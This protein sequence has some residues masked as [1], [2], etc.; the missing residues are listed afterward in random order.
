MN[1]MPGDKWVSIGMTLSMV[2]SI[3]GALFYIWGDNRDTW[4]YLVI[5]F[6][7]ILA[8]PSFS[9]FAIDTLYFGREGDSGK[10]EDP[11]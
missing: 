2:L 6:G 11:D 4:V 3:V 1:N 10:E 8:I 5:L 9:A 7:Y